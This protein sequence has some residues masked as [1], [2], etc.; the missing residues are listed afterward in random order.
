MWSDWKEQQL[1]YRKV[2]TGAGESLNSDL[3]PGQVK[4]FVQSLL[5]RSTFAGDRQARHHRPVE[6][7]AC[8]VRVY[9]TVAHLLS[10]HPPS[11]RA[12]ESVSLAV[13]CSEGL[14]ASGVELREGKDE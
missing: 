6:L 12:S 3:R 8:G 9:I 14:F 5:H 11:E 7:M 1:L 10:A 13:V 2:S 4:T